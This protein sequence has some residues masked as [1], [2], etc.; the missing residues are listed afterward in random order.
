MDMHILL[1]PVTDFGSASK[2]FFLM[3]FVGIFY[4][5]GGSNQIHKN[6]I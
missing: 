2:S 6:S 1:D 3:I 4:Q 5:S